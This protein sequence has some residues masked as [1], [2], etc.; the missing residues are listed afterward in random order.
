MLRALEMCPLA[1]FDALPPDLTH[2]RPRRSSGGPPGEPLVSCRWSTSTVWQDISALPPTSTTGRSGRSSRATSGWSRRSSAGSTGTSRPAASSSTSAPEPEASRARSSTRFRT[3]ASSSSTSTRTCSRSPRRG[4]AHTGPGRATARAVRGSA[5]ALSCGR[6]V[7]RASPCGHARREA[8]ALSRHPDA[9]EPGGLVVVGDFLV[10]PDGPERGTDEDW[11]AHME[12]NG[13]SR[14]EAEAHFAAWA[15]EDF[16]VSLPDE[17][18][19]MAAAGFP[20]P[21]S[22]GGTADRGLR[23]LQGRVTDETVTQALHRLTSYEPGREWTEPI[24]DPRIVQDLEVNDVDRYPGRTSGTSRTCRGWSFRPSCPRPPSR[25]SR[26]LPGPRTRRR[27]SW[28]WRSSRGCCSSRPA[29]SG[30]RRARA[31]AAGSSSARPGPPGRGTRSRST[32]PFRRG[33][34]AGGGALVPA[35]GARAS[36]NR[37][38]AAG[39]TPAIVLT[40]VPWR[41]GWRYR[42][43]GYRHIYWDT[44]RSS[45]SCSRSP[46]PRA[47]DARLFTRFPDTT[48]DALVGADGVDEFSTAVVALG[49]GEPPRAV[50]RGRARRDRYRAPRVPARH[51][52]PARRGPGR[53]GRAVARGRSGR[54]ARRRA[55]HRGRRASPKLAAADGPERGLPESVL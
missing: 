11:Y 25:R 36:R 2:D 34:V 17:L 3:S 33:A 28:T 23:G 26:C 10:H 15:E 47:S 50:R 51:R 38:A 31:W 54:R 41:T 5:A 53:L 39:E 4:C 43:R 35:R 37:P 49:S 32:S 9:L 14:P 8:R 13:I 20:H 29:S 48:I 52:G 16:Y 30:P 18:A 40:G 22:S 55:D 1:G 45:R 46:R 7:A 12:R 27:P 44:G 21:E 6:R 24:A 19:L 42:E